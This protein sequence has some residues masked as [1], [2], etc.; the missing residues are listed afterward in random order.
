MTAYSRYVCGNCG[1]DRL[2]SAAEVPPLCPACA[3]DAIRN[4]PDPIT[5][6]CPVCGST[7]YNPIDAVEGY[8]GHCHQFTGHT[9]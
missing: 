3:L 9:R 7:S 5:F 8:C 6:T 1:R 2:T 4:G